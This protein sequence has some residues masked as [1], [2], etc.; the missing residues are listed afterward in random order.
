[1]KHKNLAALAVA[2]LTA[3]AVIPFTACGFSFGGGTASVDSTVTSTDNADSAGSVNPTVSAGATEIPDGATEITDGYEIT[4]AGD[5]YVASEIDDKIEI[6]AEGVTLYLSD[7]TLSNKKKVIESSYGLT[8]TLIGE[9]S[10]S[11]TNTD[12]SNAIDCEGDLTVNGS[13]SLSV[14]S[15]KNGIKANSISITEATLCIEAENDGLHAEVTAYD[16]ATSEPDPSYD[17]GGYV[18][19]SDAY[20]TIDA[21]D[22]GIQADTYAYVT[23]DDTVIDIVSGGGAPS[24]VTSTSSDAA[25]GKGIKAG[26]IDWGADDAEID[27]DG[28]LIYIGG[29]DITI[30]ANDDAV[31]SNSEILIDGGTLS[32]ESGDDAVHSDDILTISGGDIAVSKC[33]EGIESAQVQITGGTM[34]IE[35][36]EDGVNAA[37]G[38]ATTVGVSNSNCKIVITGGYLSV[39][40]TGSEGDGIDSNGSIYI[41][42]GEMYVAGSSNS[43]D[44]AIDADGDIVVDGGYVFAVG[45]SGM[46]ETPT[47]SSGQYCVDYQCSSSVSANTTLYLCDSDENVIMYFTC[48]RSCQ[49]ILLSC[50]EFEK[51]STYSLY[52]GDTLLKSFTISSTITSVS[53]GGTS[54]STSGTPGNGTNSNTPGFTGGITSRNR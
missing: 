16:D 15:T 26:N 40:C 47:S 44:A 5:Y 19:I 24:T 25:E 29:G 9:N 39:N 33:Y 2:I 8:L 43:A 46:V 38:T 45:P 53:S 48:P 42:G 52:S 11:N 13:G 54:G 31:H 10:V 14:S 36:T 37:D 49:D 51:G 30:D 32:I 28:Y 18:Y 3:S 17:D 6:T 20:L 34:Q 23:G 1:M 27:W 21:A 7:A 41:S 22:D 12:G 4:E 35:S 50:P